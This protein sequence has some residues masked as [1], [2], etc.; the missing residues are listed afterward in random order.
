[1]DRRED[2]TVELDRALLLLEL[3]QH[4]IAERQVPGGK[5]DLRRDMLDH[6]RS[7]LEQIVDPGNPDGRQGCDAD[8]PDGVVERRDDAQH[9]RAMS[10]VGRADDPVRAEGEIGQQLP[11]R[12][13]CARAV[14][15]TDVGELVE[16]QRIPLP[17]LD[18]HRIGE[19]DHDL[20]QQ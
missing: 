15:A 2:G 20:R 5:R 17:Q 16:A 14:A 8:H 4:D 11:D 7:V 19:L 1:L 10:L 9:A 12:V 18:R 6:H 13:D 3:E